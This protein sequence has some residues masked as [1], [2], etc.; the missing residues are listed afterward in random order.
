MRNRILFLAL[1][2]AL[3][4]LVP[5]ASANSVGFN[6]SCGGTSCGTVKITDIS[7]G[8]SVQVTMTGG[9]SSQ[10]QANSGGVLINTI[11]GLTL[12]LNSFSTE[13]GSSSA[14]LNAGV[15]NG[16]GSFTWGVVKFGLPHGNTSVSDVS[17][18]LTG[19]SVANLLANGNSN[20]V[21]VH[22]CSPGS[23]ANSCPSPTGFATSTQIP[24]VPEPGT[25]SLLGT[26]L[27]GLAGLA[28]RRFLR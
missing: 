15:N 8:V 11:G 13:L 12:S 9:Y 24:S 1:A 14:H 6:L 28:R 7:G 3:L 5:A 17:F 10:A 26:G 25:L 4:T 18:N 2:V 19:L 23:P 20:V 22:Y 16:S 27:I 21:S